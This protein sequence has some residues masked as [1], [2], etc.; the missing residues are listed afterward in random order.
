MRGIGVAVE[1][2]V[3]VSEV[4]DDRYARSHELVGVG[5]DDGVA[6][7]PLPVRKVLPGVPQARECHYLAVGEVEGEGVLVLGAD[8][9]PL[10]EAGGGNQAASLLEGLAVDARGCEHHMGWP[11]YEGRRMY[12]PSDN[13]EQPIDRNNKPRGWLPKDVLFLHSSF[14]RQTSTAEIKGLLVDNEKTR[15]R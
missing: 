12:T 8:P 13:L 11:A 7:E 9:L 3:E 5:G 14:Q 6:L 10:V 2:A 1:L 15:L 4:E